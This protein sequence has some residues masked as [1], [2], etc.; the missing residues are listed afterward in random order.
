[1]KSILLLPVLTLALNLSALAAVEPGETAP[2]FTLK[3]SKGNSQ[4]LSSYSGKFVVLEWMNS[5]CPFVKK[6]YS[7]G[8]M[9][10]LQKEYTG[11]GVVWL[12][13]I[14]SAPGK[15]GYCTGPQAEANTK[16]QKASPTA[17]LLDPSGEVG[18]MYGAKTTPHMF[19]INPEGKL[20]YMGA[21]D[22]IRSSNSS[23]CAKADN[24]IRQTLDAALA[25]KPVPTPETKSYGCSVKY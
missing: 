3:D 6:H 24:Y 8:N 19:V 23:D 11:K 9:Q 1:M 14:S 20:I 2:D 21:I 22:S 7:I 12:S 4:K 15:Q 10:S 17:V 13:I 16:D 25:D 18:Q 5:E